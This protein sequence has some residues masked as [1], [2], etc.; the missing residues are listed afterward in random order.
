MVLNNEW[1]GQESTE[2]SGPR[3]EPD[4]R[5]VL[6][7]ER[8]LSAAFPKPASIFVFD[9]HLSVARPF[10]TRQSTQAFSSVIGHMS[11]DVLQ[12]EIAASATTDIKLYN[13]HKRGL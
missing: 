9:C 12:P 7:A 1:R 4:R 11:G 3:S 13:G 2:P 6:A 8:G 10:D 5:P